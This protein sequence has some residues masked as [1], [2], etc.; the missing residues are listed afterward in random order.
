MVDYL[1]Y[2][3][4]VKL[5]KKA[6]GSPHFKLLVPFELEKHGLGIE[7]VE[8]WEDPVFW[9]GKRTTVV[10]V[11]ALEAFGKALP[12]LM[13]EEDWMSYEKTFQTFLKKVQNLLEKE[14]VKY[15]TFYNLYN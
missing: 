3:P 7:E 14:E 4:A 8:G 13:E 15:L 10:F 11:E 6:I 12:R 2:K 5:V 1:Y 9:K